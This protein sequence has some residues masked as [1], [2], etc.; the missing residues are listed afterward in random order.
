MFDIGANMGYVSLCLAKRVGPTG[1]VFA[2]EPV[3]ANIELLRKNI[4]LNRTKNINLFEVAASDLRGEATI[5]IA[6][7]LSTASLIWHANDQSAVEVSVRMEPIDE[8]VDAGGLPL[9]SFVKIDVEGAEGLVLAGMRRTITKARP[10]I[11][12]QCSQAGRETTWPMLRGFEY[13][14]Q[15]AITRKPILDFEQYRHSDFLW[16]PPR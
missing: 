5:R 7:N 12:L 4:A 11:F 16:L 13:Q 8:L 14:C 1:R 15:S 3:P 9:P 6:G 10:V 2:F